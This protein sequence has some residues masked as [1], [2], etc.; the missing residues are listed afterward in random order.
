M[1]DA[2]PGPPRLVSLLGVEIRVHVSWAI[3]ALFIAWSLASGSLP[4][5]FAGLPAGAY[6]SMAGIIVMGLAAS[7]VL[8]ELAHALVGRA[9][10]VPVNRITLFLFGGGAELTEE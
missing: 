10:G 2:R 4:M 5:L 3:M 8:H 7:I 6:W 1:P 9:M